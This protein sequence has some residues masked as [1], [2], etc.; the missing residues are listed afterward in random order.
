M[1]TALIL[2]IAFAGYLLGRIGDYYLNPLL[3][4]PAWA[5]HHWIYGVILMIIGLVTME[6]YSIGLWLFSFGVG[7]FISDFNDF[8]DLKFIGSDNKDKLKFWGID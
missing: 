7:H 8:V 4:D 6:N 5:P 2:L 1:F 3:K